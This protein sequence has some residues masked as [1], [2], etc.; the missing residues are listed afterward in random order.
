[1]SFG[2]TTMKKASMKGQE[3]EEVVRDEEG[4]EGEDGGEGE[5][6]DGMKVEGEKEMEEGG[7]EEG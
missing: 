2:M 5:E 6:G 4:E 3:E 7:Q 1:M